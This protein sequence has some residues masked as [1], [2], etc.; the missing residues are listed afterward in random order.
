[1][2]NSAKKLFKNPD[3]LHAYNEII[4]NQLNTN[5]IEPNLETDSISP[6]H[7]HYLLH[8]PI[9][10]DGKTK[11]ICMVYDAS[12]NAS[13]PSLN[14]CLYPGPALCESLFGVLL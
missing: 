11:K 9:I 5:I 3:L 1:M 12:S 4:I 2:S 13:V 8:R 10:K 14:D 6:G 7:V